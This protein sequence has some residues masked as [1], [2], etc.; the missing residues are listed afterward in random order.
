MARKAGPGRGHRL[1]Y[2]P[3]PVGLKVHRNVASE[4]DRLADAAGMTRSGYLTALV[5][6]KA[7]KNLEDLLVPENNQEELRETA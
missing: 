4:L 1:S 6:E 3:V 5:A 7:R 2:T